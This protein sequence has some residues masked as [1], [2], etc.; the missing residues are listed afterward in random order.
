MAD[1]VRSEDRS[2]VL[3]PLRD[4]LH[5]E[6]AGGVALLVAARRR[7][8]VGE[9]AVAGR[10]TSSCGTPCWRIDLG[11]HVLDLDLRG[12]DQRRPDDDL[13]LRRR[14][15]DQ[16]RARR[17]RAARAAARRPPGHRRRRRDGRAGRSSTSP[18]TPAAT[19]PSGWAHPDGHRHRHGRRRAQP[20]RS[21]RRP[22]AEAV[23]A[24]AGHRRRH[25]RHRRSSPS[26]YS[27]DLDVRSRRSSPPASWSSVAFARRLQV[28]LAVVYV[29]LGVALWLA[30]HESGR[31]RHDRRRR[32]SA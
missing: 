25:R 1:R 30:L 22:V 21:P 17:R 2:V 10:P 6:A 29:V 8:R 15:G 26:F 3:R 23:P 24:D 9:L 5:T 27:D 13:L 28:Q 32:R 18:S 12:V 7:P 31:P 16:A 4:F 20:A 19:A 11:D 14:P